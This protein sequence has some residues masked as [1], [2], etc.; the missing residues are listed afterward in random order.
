TEELRRQL[1]VARAQSLPEDEQA[2]AQAE[3][4]KAAIDAK[5]RAE[6]EFLRKRLEGERGYLDVALRG[7][8][9]LKEKR[10]EYAGMPNKELPELSA[11]AEI[12]ARLEAA[13]LRRDDARNK[14]AEL[15]AQLQE[16]FR[17]ARE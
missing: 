8:E 7:I 13:E 16:N 5:L 11:E 17:K 12:P 10:A 6:E 2:S 15:E 4:E 14:I 3:V 9:R 1:D